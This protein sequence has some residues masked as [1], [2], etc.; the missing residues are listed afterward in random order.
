MKRL[1]VTLAALRRARRSRARARAPAR[2]LHRQPAHRDR[3]L[4]RSRLCPLRARPGRDPDV[5]ARAHVSVGPPSRG[6]RARNLELRLDGRRA[7][8]RCSSAASPSGPARAASKTLRFDAVYVAAGPGRTTSL[9]AH[10]PRS[11]LRLADRL[12]GGR[13][14]GRRRGS[15]PRRRASPLRV[16]SNGAPRVPGRATPLAA[17]RHAQPRLPSRSG[18][19]PARA[20]PL[21]GEAAAD[22][23]ER[24][25]RVARVARRP[26]ARRDPALARGCCLLGRGPR[27]HAG[28]RQGDRRRA[29]W[30]A[31]RAGRS[32][33]S[34]SAASSRSRTRS[35]SSRSAS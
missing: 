13:R 1:L 3:A 5:P 35:A 6:R 11:Q 9:A 8:L 14:P 18:T 22:T 32:T 20:P 15:A 31:R 29:I 34:C 17:R 7:Q 4:R 10:V 12:E 26:L 28:P 23:R 25:L 24:R 27:A 33:P 16:A 2:Q 21:R 19:V 30:W